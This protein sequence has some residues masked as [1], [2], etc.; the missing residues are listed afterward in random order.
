MYFSLLVIILILGLLQQQQ[1]RERERERREKERRELERRELERERERLLQQQRYAETAKHLS[2]AV[3]RDRSPM[4]NGTDPAEI[5]VKEEPRTKEEE[6]LGR[7][8]PRYHPYLR[9]PPGLQP[10]SVLDRSRMLGHGLAAH[11]PPHHAGLY[12]HPADP[13]YRGYDPLRYNPLV[14]AMRAE[15]ERAKLFGGYGAPHPAQLRPKDP[16]LL[17]LRPGPGPPP[18]HKLCATPPADLLKKDEPR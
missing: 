10:P 8:D 1:E 15:E 18:T 13:F 2:P 12:P 6:M 3:L 14:D 16:G 11:Y 4:R 9:H 7:A 17:H 5:R